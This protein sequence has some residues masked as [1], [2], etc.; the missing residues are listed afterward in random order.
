[1]S[2]LEKKSR[3]YRYKC[4]IDKFISHKSPLV[5]ISSHNK[6]CLDI[7][8]K[9]LDHLIAIFLVTTFHGKTESKNRKFHGY[10]MACGVDIAMIIVN[11]TDRYYC[12]KD[13][14]D[15]EK[16]CNFVPELVAKMYNC[17]S[18]N[19]DSLKLS[20]PKDEIIRINQQCIDYLSKGIANLTQI[21]KHDSES[22]IRKTDFNDYRF[23]KPAD[24]KKYSKLKYVSDEIL[25]SH[26]DNKYG[27]ASK[28]AL[29]FGWLFGMGDL[30]KIGEIEALGRHMGI[31]F[32]IAYD[33]ENIEQDL[34]KCEG[35]TFN[36]VINKGIKESFS[37]Y[38]THKQILIEGILK[39]KLWSNTIKEILDLIEDKV[40]DGLKCASIDENCEYSE[41]SN[42]LM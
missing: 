35:Y 9:L 41:F 20:L 3:I 4:S 38:E 31:V 8:Y 1:M 5:L 36:M 33:F 22:T 7:T 6:K 40:D 19:I 2:E 32:K 30:T 23:K 27:F 12:Y 18:Q 28:M 26:I 10:F 34:Q 39:L 14:I 25:Y 17:L 24:K 11:I 16:W 15:Y 42:S 29:L 37:I 13:V 21:P